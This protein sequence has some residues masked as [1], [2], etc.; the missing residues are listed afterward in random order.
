MWRHDQLSHDECHITINMATGVWAKLV[1]KMVLFSTVVKH[2]SYNR[3]IMGRSIGSRKLVNRSY[4]R[5]TNNY[6]IYFLCYNMVFAHT[7]E[8]IKNNSS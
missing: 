5:S 8:M 6:G 2:H 3:P 1:L 4:N 7:K